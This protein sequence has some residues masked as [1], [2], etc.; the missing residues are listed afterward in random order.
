M[1]EANECEA[2]CERIALASGSQVAGGAKDLALRVT[3]QLAG[4]PLSA[5]HLGQH[6]AA[7]FCS[8]CKVAGARTRMMYITSFV[9]MSHDVLWLYGGGV[10]GW[11]SLQ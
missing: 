3:A 4:L 9:D 10:H 1:R 8:W 7:V 11:Q 2:G 5:G 6:V